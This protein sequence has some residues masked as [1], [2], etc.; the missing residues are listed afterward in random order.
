MSY[1]PHKIIFDMLLKPSVLSK[2]CNMSKREMA[3]DP[4]ERVNIPCLMDDIRLCLIDLITN[5]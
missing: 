4:P 2:Q 5:N 1:V 3:L